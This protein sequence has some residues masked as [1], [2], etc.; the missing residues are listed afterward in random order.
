MLLS[1]ARAAAMMPAV[2]RH[3]PAESEESRALYASIRRTAAMF[4]LYLPAHH[5]RSLLPSLKIRKTPS[6]APVEP[7][8]KKV[9]ARSRERHAV[10]A[11]GP[12]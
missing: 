9:T 5:S 12:S 4:P 11:I 7:C 2:I 8:L 10:R 6:T 3:Q 1:S